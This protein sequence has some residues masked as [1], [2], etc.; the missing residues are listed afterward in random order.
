MSNLKT[1]QH[2][3]AVT[4]IRDVAKH[5]GVS[6]TTASAA[7]HQTGRISEQRRAQI[8]KVAQEIGYQPRTAARLMRSK[9]TGHLGLVLNQVDPLAAFKHGG[10]RHYIA[11]FIKACEQRNIPYHLDFCDISNDHLNLPRH[12]AGGLVDGILVLG[13]DVDRT[14]HDTSPMHRWLSASFSKPAI[15]LSSQSHWSVLGDAEE[16]IVLALRKLHEMGHRKIGFVSGDYNV[17]YNQKF[18]MGFNRAINDLGLQTQDDWQIHLDK[19]LNRTPV[20]MDDVMQ[21]TT[22]ILQS[23]DRPTAFYCNGGEKMRAVI[24]AARVTGLNVPNQLSVIGNCSPIYADDAYPRLSAVHT[25]VQTIINHALDMLLR[26]IAKPDT[27][28]QAMKII[29]QLVLRQTTASPE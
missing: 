1:G 29:P 2:A 16:G 6:L 3:D 20:V 25:D 24:E 9:N 11:H 14:Q 4:T 10:H 26:C 27:E 17:K 7:L 5:A 15:T 19:S 28:S 13:D 8:I 12:A 18:W 21:R 22:L 23:D